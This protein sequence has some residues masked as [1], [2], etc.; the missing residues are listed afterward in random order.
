MLINFFGA[1]GSGKS[2][3]AMKLCGYLKGK[4]RDVEFAPEYIKTLIALGEHS[5]SGLEL[6]AMQFKQIR[7]FEQ[8][9]DIVITDSPVLLASIYSEIGKEFSEEY[10]RCL[11]EMSEALHDLFLE[12]R[13]IIV[14]PMVKEELYQKKL[15]FQNYGESLEIYENYFKNL[16]AYDLEVD[17]NTPVERIFTGL[18]L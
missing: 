13:N 16:L 3:L 11:K 10:R 5:Y 7:A 8:T 12:K 6:L 14:R 1:P 15:R 4:G 18:R 9:S 17:C 2:T